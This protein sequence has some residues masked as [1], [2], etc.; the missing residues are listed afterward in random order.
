M[1]P[2]KVIEDFEV[3][4]RGDPVV[5][6]WLY[7]IKVRHGVMLGWR[8]GD[9]IESVMLQIG[10]FSGLPATVFLPFV[11]AKDGTIFACNALE[12]NQPLDRTL[13]RLIGSLTAARVEVMFGDG[14]LFQ[15]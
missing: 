4:A 3:A 12:W 6:S 10:R 13:H 7:L 1:E 5:P 15:L 2:Y 8:K 11:Q 9:P 14:V